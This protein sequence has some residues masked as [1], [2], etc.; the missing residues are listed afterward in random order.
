MLIS[1]EKSYVARWKLLRQAAR[2]VA[3]QARHA[4][5]S[6]ALRT[7]GTTLV[8]CAKKYMAVEDE[9]AAADQ[10]DGRELAQA[11]A[12]VDSL[13]S[14][15]RMW[16]GLLVR[17]VTSFDA[18]PFTERFTVPEDVTSSARQLVHLVQSGG[19]GDEPLPYAE[20]LVADLTEAIQHATKEQEE[21]QDSLARVQELRAES[22]K[23]GLEL[24]GHL[25]ALRRVLRNV[26]GP[27][28]RDYQRL[29]TDLVNHGDDEQAILGAIAN[30]P[31][32]EPEAY[33]TGL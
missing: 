15:I 12:G 5:K 23:L 18:T 16:M 2:A 7:F 26:L 20:E 13:R 29:R 22:R 27:S 14:K 10:R 31:D 21:A 11:K 24:Q 17:D 8:P 4:D 9:L 19:T 1:D 32:A 6:P 30:D 25:V 28:H 33:S 3:V